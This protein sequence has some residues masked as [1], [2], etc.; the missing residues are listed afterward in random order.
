MR[1]KR[2]AECLIQLSITEM[3][4]LGIRVKSDGDSD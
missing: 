4:V 2:P 1:L 3:V